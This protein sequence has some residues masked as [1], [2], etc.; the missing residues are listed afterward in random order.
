MTLSF[1]KIAIA[2]VAVAV[3]AYGVTEVRGPNGYTQLIQKREQLRVLE[4][5]NRRLHDDIDRLEKRVGK[6]KSDTTLQELEVRKRL[7]LVKPGETVYVLQ[8]KA[9]KPA[10]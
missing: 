6:L 7:G 1:G 5:E 4:Q 8:D 9:A 10:K 2:I 3:I